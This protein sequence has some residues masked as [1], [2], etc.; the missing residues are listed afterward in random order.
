MRLLFNVID[1][2]KNKK[3]PELLKKCEKNL[4]K[5]KKTLDKIGFIMYN[6]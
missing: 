1:F 2:E 3:C 4:Q 5:Q 6:N